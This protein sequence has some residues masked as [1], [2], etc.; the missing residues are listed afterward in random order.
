MVL[1]FLTLLFS[2][3]P[4]H[5]TAEERLAII[6]SNVRDLREAQVEMLQALESLQKKIDSVETVDAWFKENFLQILL[7][8]W[9]GY[10]KGKYHIGKRKNGNGHPVPN[11]NGS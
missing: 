7:F 6:E 5:L 2:G 9:L 8:A 3:Q 1:L 10:D 11:G 4:L